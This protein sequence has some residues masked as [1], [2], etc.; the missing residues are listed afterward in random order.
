M[1]MVLLPLPATFSTEWRK[2]AVR[3]AKIR[4]T[5]PLHSIDILVQ[6]MFEVSNNFNVGFLDYIEVH[7]KIEWVGDCNDLNASYADGYVRV[8]EGSPGVVLTT[9]GVRELGFINGIAGRRSSITYFVRTLTFSVRV[10]QYT[11]TC[12]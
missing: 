8:K 3:C 7:P 1:L 12:Q 4:G 5:C 9:F 10:Q 11:S 6:H 2:P